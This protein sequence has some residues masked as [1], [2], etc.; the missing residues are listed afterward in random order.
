MTNQTGQWI[1]V[2]QSQDLGAKPPGFCFLFKREKKDDRIMTFMSLNSND[3]Y[4]SLLMKKIFLMKKH[5][6]Q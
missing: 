6:L 3:Q 2:H 1:S 5:F 4:F